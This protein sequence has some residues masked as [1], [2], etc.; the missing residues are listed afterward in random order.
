MSKMVVGRYAP[1]PTGR[2]HLGNVRTALLAWLSARLQ[3]GKFYLRIE[4]IDTARVVQGS[5]DQAMRDLEWLGLDWDGKVE[6]Q[7]QRLELYEDALSDLR[8]RDLTY[9]CF[10]S[11]KTIQQAVAQK[12]TESQASGMLVY[13]QTCRG[14]SDEQQHQKAKTKSAAIRLKTQQG[15]SEFDD[16]ICGV[17]A[18]D[19]QNQMGDFVLKRA[20]GLHAYQLAVT[21]DDIEQGISEVVRGADL[22]NETFKQRYLAS[23]MSATPIDYAHVPLLL[24]AKG[25]K[26]SKRDGSES[27]DHYRAAK[28]ELSDQRLAGSLVASFAHDLGLLVTDSISANDLLSELDYASFLAVLRSQSDAAGDDL[29]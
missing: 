3:G 25:N 21:V 27:I 5:A 26:M 22:L 18:I 4:D 12:N 2:L 28:P 15:K 16:L 24:D 29:R 17:Q 10:C 1:S 7:T 6:Y 13:P 20:D 19:L 23:F 14:L 9:P 8:K 11:R